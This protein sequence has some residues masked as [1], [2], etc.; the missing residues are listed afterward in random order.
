MVASPRLAIIGCGVAAE[1]RMAEGLRRAGWAPA[2]LVDETPERLDRVG[3]KLGLTNAVKTPDWRSALNA[4]DAALVTGPLA[5]HGPIGTALV[6]AGKHVFI[7]APLA[8]TQAEGEAMIAA[9]RGKG[10][11]VSAGT[12]RRG[13]HV[14]RWTKALLD[15]K[16]LGDI[17]RFDLRE[18]TLHSCDRDADPLLRPNLAAGVLADP[19]AGVLD[20]LQWW[21]GD[22]VSLDYADD[23]QSGV[24]ANCV[25]KATLASGASGQIELS[26]ARRLRN[27]ARIEGTLGFV[28]VHLWKNEVVAGSPNALAFQHEG[29]GPRAMKP[30]AF[31]QL[32][33]AALADFRS[34][35]QS[36]AQSAHATADGLALAALFERCLASRRAL[37]HPWSVAQEV[38]KGLPQGAK[39]LVTGG[40]GS[41]G[42]SLV[43]RLVQDYRA[44]VRCTVRDAGRIGRLSSFPVEIVPVDLGDAAGVSRAVAGVDYVFHCA[45]DPNKPQRNFGDLENM[46]QACTA[47]AVR[48]LVHT[49]TMAVYEP[50]P[51]GAV[52]EQT[53]DGNRS[54]VYVDTK[55]KLEKMLFD[56]VKTRGLLASIVQ[57][58]IVYGPYSTTWTTRP[59]VALMYGTVFLPDAGAGVCN[60]VYIDDLIDGMLLAAVTPAAVGERFILSGPQAVTWATFYN[61]MA[62]ALGAKP[63]QF[64]SSEPTPVGPNGL[65]KVLHTVSNPKRLVK[66]A[67]NF[68]PAKRALRAVVKRLP[69]PLR[70]LATGL[71]GDA[72]WQPRGGQ[73]MMPNGG[74]LAF[75]K[76]KGAADLSKPRAK[77]GYA[78]KV[79]FQRGLALTVSYLKWAYQDIP[80]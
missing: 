53:P 59:A 9:A 37:I 69:A 57:P 47:H 46:I 49:S 63:P 77:L 73:V 27:T 42:G 67:I 26:H 60:P 62:K 10:I 5:S 40:T 33:A 41:I 20:L 21:L 64:M 68:G 75:Y 16:T 30:Q 54:N 80:H 23:K 12:Y 25:L 52:S 36:G 6:E 65:R 32:Y 38:V 17:K 78:P 29:V 44:Q 45:Y 18:D 72:S 55:L 19:G 14:A 15:S 48:R 71:A 7:D 74:L 1:T 34:K 3:R 61:D 39:V 28:E 35:I 4:F 11:V 70:K 50:F 22:L 31:A 13:L 76:S 43:E 56:A 8:A 51:E 66:A 58:A 24:A 2:V 79:D